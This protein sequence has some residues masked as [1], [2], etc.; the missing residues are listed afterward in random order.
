MSFMSLR[1]V[2][3]SLSLAAFAAAASDPASLRALVGDADY[4]AM[5]LDK[6]T[7]EEQDR[8]T[9]WLERRLAGQPVPIAPPT[10]SFGVGTATVSA[11]L[12]PPGAAVAAAPVVASSVAAAPAV[13]APPTPPPPA[14]VGVGTVAAFGLPQ[15]DVDG[16]IKELRAKVVGEFTGWDGKTIFKL[17]NGQ[18]W[19]QSTPGTY[20]FKATDPEVIIEKALLGYK[21]RLVETR[22][23]IAVRRVK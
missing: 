18:V 23:S 19:R 9:R 2:L 17:D 15:D 4:A 1:L 3:L 6:L 16:D 20:R 11:T 7:A 8:L 21:L 13:A 22:R 12:V 10:V 14:T 5:G